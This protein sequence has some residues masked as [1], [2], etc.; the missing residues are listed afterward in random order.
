MSY[1]KDTKKVFRWPKKYQDIV[2]LLTS[3]DTEKNQ[4]KCFEYN[5]HVMVFAACVGL[6]NG[7]YETG[8]IETGT[9]AGEIRIE[10]FESHNFKSLPLSY[11]IVLIALLYKRDPNFLRIKFMDG[12]NERSGDDEVLEIFSRL[13]FAGLKYLQSFYY[14]STEID[15]LSIIRSEIEKSVI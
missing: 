4:I 1:F 7:I 13:A 12:D 8:K 15:S 11:Y 14:S 10:Y 6:K 9:D 2:D 3:S 5:T